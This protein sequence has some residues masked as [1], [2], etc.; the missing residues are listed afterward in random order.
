MIIEC[1]AC[2][3]EWDYKGLNDWYATCPNCRRLVKIK[4]ELNSTD[5]KVD[6]ASSSK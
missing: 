4:E 6:D 5:S 3:K 1:K 2:K